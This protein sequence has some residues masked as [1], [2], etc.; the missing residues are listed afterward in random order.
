M[1]AAVAI[2]YFHRKIGPI[3]YYT[4]PEENLVDEEKA[5]LAEFMDQ[6]Y[7]EGFFTHKFGNLASMNFYFE[8]NSD[9]ARGNKEML[10][11]SFVIDKTPTQAI[12]ALLK[13]ATSNFAER[14]KNQANLFKAFYTTEDA[15]VSEAD[16][17]DIKSFSSDVRIWLKELYWMGIEELRERTEEEKWAS[18]MC[19]PEIFNVIKKISKGPMAKEDLEKWFDLH[20]ANHDLDKILQ[21]LEE[22][23]FIF[24]NSI[25]QDTYVLLV[26]EVV[27]A[28]VPP[29]CIIEMEEFS[30]ET[31]D[32]TEL[33]IN[34][35]RDIFEEYEPNSEDSLALFKIF[36]DPKLY[37]VIT[38][39]RDGPLPKDKILALYSENS[40]KNLLD[41]L[42]LL[43]K[44]N[45]IQDFSYAGE[46][47]F[48]LVSDVMLTASFPEYL[49]R[50]LPK[51]TKGYI[52]QAYS[53]RRIASEDEDSTSE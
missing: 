17:T 2:S 53:Y 26:K 43:G 20:F 39:L 27:I 35:V 15:Q 34:A 25:G 18:V 5:R 13:K 16:F 3:V 49:K 21:E 42:E 10:M 30:P 14:L 11:I 9:W 22:E 44:M 32:L 23:K 7:E 4:F 47:L 38:K 24:I 1:Q 52:A 12:E 28:R 29:D 41:S 46:H 51:E 33:Y 40:S 31:A 8:I 37:N 45:I 6:I 36:D 50:L 19:K 48:L